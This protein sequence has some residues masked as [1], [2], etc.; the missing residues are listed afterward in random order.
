MVSAAAA[1]LQ[2]AVKYQVDQVVP[3]AANSHAQVAA[4]GVSPAASSRALK[5]EKKK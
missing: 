2:E 5:G 4:L 3:L 1:A